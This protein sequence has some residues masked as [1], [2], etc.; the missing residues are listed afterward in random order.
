MAS[1]KPGEASSSQNANAE[2][3]NHC[4]K[5]TVARHGGRFSLKIVLLRNHNHF[6]MRIVKLSITASN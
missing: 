3:S 4:T 6:S 5:E 1:G 2:S